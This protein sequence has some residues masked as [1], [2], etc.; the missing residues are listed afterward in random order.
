MGT[1]GSFEIVRT[2][3]SYFFSPSGHGKWT[4]TVHFRIFANYSNAKNFQEGS[5]GAIWKLTSWRFRKCGSFLFYH[6]LNKTYGCSKSTES[7]ILSLSSKLCG[8]KKNWY[9][10]LQLALDSARFEFTLKMRLN[11]IWPKDPTYAIFLKSWV[12]KDVKYD[13]PMCQYHSTRPQPIQLV[14]TMQKKLFTSSFQAKFLKIWFTKVTG[15]SIKSY[16]PVNIFVPQ[17]QLV[18]GACFGP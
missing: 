6:F 14:P 1:S 4:K 10:S 5:E 17:S 3:A 2:T 9:G 16:E 15:T 7:E 18:L 11:R 12:F 8:V 13:I